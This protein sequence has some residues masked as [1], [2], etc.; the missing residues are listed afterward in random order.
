M[1][2]LQTIAVAQDVDLSAANG[3]LS[4]TTNIG[5]ITLDG[6]AGENEIKTPGGTG[7][8]LLGAI[9]NSGT[10]S[11]LI[12]TTAT[13]TTSGDITLNGAVTGVGYVTINAGSTSSG[14]T[15]DVAINAN[16]TAADANGG[17]GIDIDAT[18]DVTVAGT[19]TT[20]DSGTA[21]DIDIDAANEFT[22][23]SGGVDS[24]N[25]VFITATAND[26]NLAAGLTADNEVTVFLHPVVYFK[27][28]VT[29]WQPM[30]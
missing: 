25:D 8:I 30:M 14:N 23:S 28:P 10:A 26:V 12:I 22:L 24:D 20:S 29:Y 19:L 9:G 7:D 13:G 17:T 27:L 5:S 16:I 4:A 18:N 3:D 21:L 2:N 15:G 11:D 6:T 1:D